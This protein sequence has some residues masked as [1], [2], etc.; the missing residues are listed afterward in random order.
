MKH[1]IDWAWG[2]LF[3]ETVATIGLIFGGALD[4]HPQLRVMVPHGG[5][6]IP[7]QIGRLQYHAAVY[8]RGND[9]FA[10]EGFERPVTD[11]LRQFYFDTVVHEPAS[12]KLL[13]DVIGEDNVVMGSNYPGWD[14]APIWD[15]IRSMPDLSDTAKAKILGA[16][17]AERLFKSALTHR[18]ASQNITDT[19]ESVQ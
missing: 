16:N 18:G 15:T 7:Y 9:R 14:N 5:G 19:T 3:T 6:M 10:G 17:A 4:R 12:I 1:Q 11:Y 2:Y 8:G 13:V